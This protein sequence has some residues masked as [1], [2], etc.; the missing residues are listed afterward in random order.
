MTLRTLLG[1]YDR[2]L[3]K[4]YNNER[5]HPEKY[6]DAVSAADFYESASSALKAAKG[7]I[8]SYGEKGL[9]PLFLLCKAFFYENKRVT[10]M[11][12]ENF[13]S[14]EKLSLFQCEALPVLLYAAAGAVISESYPE[15]SEQISRYSFH[16]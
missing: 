11:K 6:K 7:F 13:F 12:L 9:M 16:L 14:D 4:I 15:K 8:S 2:K 5:R 3:R 1:K 10:R